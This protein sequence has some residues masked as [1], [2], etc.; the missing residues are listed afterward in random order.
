MRYLAWFLLAIALCPMGACG[1]QSVPVEGYLPEPLPNSSWI[2]SGDIQTYDVETL[3]DLVD[4]QAD[5]FFAYAFQS[6]DVQTYDDGG[7]TSIR[8]EVWQ[9]ATPSDAYGLFSAYRS[10]EPLEVGNEATGDLERRI[11]FWQDRYFIRLIASAEVT[12][13]DLLAFARATSNLLPEGGQPPSLLERLPGV[14][15]A[16]QSVV[17]FHQEISIQ[18]YLW[19]GGQNIL[20]LSTETDGLLASYTSDA[21]PLYLLLVQYSTTEDARAGLDALQKASV[22]GLVVSDAQHKLLGA[23]FGAATRDV[24]LSLIKDLL[25]EE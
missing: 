9:L 6:V 11:V 15:L 3:Y 8:I 18:D 2:R 23:V 25:V 4:G 12:G 1:S 21:G 24:G 7:G 14:G 22:D 17:F 10:G 19:L 16:E 13:G 20:G 5:A